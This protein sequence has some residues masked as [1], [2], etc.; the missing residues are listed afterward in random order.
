MIVNSESEFINEKIRIFRTKQF[1]FFLVFSY[2]SKLSKNAKLFIQGEKCSDNYIH[3]QQANRNKGTE[4]QEWNVILKEN[5]IN[6]K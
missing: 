6:R 1:Y 3:K 4:K 2:T 5:P